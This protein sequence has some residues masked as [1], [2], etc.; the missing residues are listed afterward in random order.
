MKGEKNIAEFK[1][2]YESLWKAIIRPPRDTY[3]LSYIGDLKFVHDNKTYIKKEYKIKSS[4]G[5]LMKCIFIKQQFDNDK[6]HKLP[7]VI[8]LHGNSSSLIE[9]IRLSSCLLE[10]NINVFT[11]DFPGC[12]HSEGEY[13]SLG[14]H[15]KNDL[16]EIVDFLSTLPDVGNIG[17]WGRSMGAAT[18]LIYGYKDN[19]IKAMCLDSPFSDIRVLAKDLSYKYM[20]IPG[21]LVDTTLFFLKRTLMEKNNFDLFDLKPIEHASETTIP[22]L[23]I[24]AKNDNLIPLEHT[25]KIYEAYGGEKYLNIIEGDH[26]TPRQKNILENIKKFFIK[27]LK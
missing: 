6:K 18:G 19:K 26:N 5:Y 12:G 1:F 3:P 4:R 23:L 11:F 20:S 21:F 16:K 17:L 9:G 13:I 22:V 15:E 14:Y 24:H 10:A 7:V 25:I 8:Y 2:S 27:H